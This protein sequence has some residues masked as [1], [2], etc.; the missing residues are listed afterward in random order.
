MVENPIICNCN[1]ISRVTIV[2]AI[3]DKKLK[4]EEA[5]GDET[6]AGT[7]CGGCSSDIQEILEEN[8]CN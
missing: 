6:K 5:V 2:D 4:T 8:V 1:D 3:K 7:V